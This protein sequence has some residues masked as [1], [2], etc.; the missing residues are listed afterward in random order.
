MAYQDISPRYR[1]FTA[2]N[3][4]K[5]NQ[6]VHTS[7]ASTNAFNCWWYQTLSRHSAMVA[8]ASTIMSKNRRI[9]TLD[10]ASD[11]HTH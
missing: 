5:E 6:F 3:T 1:L 7:G 4:L 11:G 10:C 2:L 8:Q 9:G